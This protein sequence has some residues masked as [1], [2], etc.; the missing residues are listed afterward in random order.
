MKKLAWLLAVVLFVGLALYPIAAQINWGDHI[1]RGDDMAGWLG[2]TTVGRDD[3]ETASVFASEVCGHDVRFDLDGK[4]HAWW[5]AMA[6]RKEVGHFFIHSPF[7]N[8]IW[9][10]LGADRWTCAARFEVVMRDRGHV[11]WLPRWLL[12][13]P[14]F[15]WFKELHIEE[16]R[17]LERIP[18]PTAPDSVKAL[19]P[20]ECVEGTLHPGETVKYQARIPKVSQ[21]VEI[22]PYWDWPGGEPLQVILTKDGQPMHSHIDEDGGGTY[23]IVMHNQVTVS[24]QFTLRISWGTVGRGY[25][26]TTDTWWK[27]EVPPP[28]GH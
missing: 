1:E 12:P 22:F 19:L 9:F 23:N 15:D 18:R 26:P 21:N 28:P 7:R 24:R 14:H 4:E 3:V 16:R 6:E 27:W 5:M 8:V 17:L 10:V 20:G 25:C 13:F 11:I 2:D